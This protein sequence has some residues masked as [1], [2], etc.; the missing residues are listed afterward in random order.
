MQVIFLYVSYFNLGFIL[1]RLFLLTV[2]TFVYHYPKRRILTYDF[3]LVESFLDIQTVKFD[4]GDLSVLMEVSMKIYVCNVK[5][6]SLQQFKNFSE[7][8]AS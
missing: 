1:R 4:K 5:I 3:I 8:S 2:S 6:F 7:E